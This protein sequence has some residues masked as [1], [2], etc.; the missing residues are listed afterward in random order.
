MKAWKTGQL[1][2][3]VL[4]AWALGAGWAAA[5]FNADRLLLTW[6]SDPTSTMT[7]QWLSEGIRLP[8]V[9]HEAPDPVP[10]DVP[11]VS[12]LAADAPLEAWWDDG[13]PLSYLTDPEH[14]V[15]DPEIFG[16]E[17]RLAWN[18]AGLLLGLRVRNRIHYEQPDMDL[19]WQADSIEVYFSDAVGSSHRTVLMVSPGFDSEIGE[20]RSRIF[21]RDGETAGENL[22][23]HV[24]TRKTAS[25]YTAFILLP[26]E[27]LPR[28]EPREGGGFALQ[29]YIND[30]EGP[31]REE[32][33]TIGLHPS[34]LGAADRT[35]AYAFRLAQ[36]AGDPVQARAEV[37]EDEGRFIARIY[38]A[39]ALAGE[40]VVVRSG[41][42]E[43]TS[44]E[45]RPDGFRA[46][47]EAELPAPPDGRRWGQLDAVLE[48]AWLAVM[49]APEW[50]GVESPEAATV[51]YW[52]AHAPEDRAAAVT[53]MLPV[54]QRRG[55]FRQR[56]ELTGLEPGTAYRFQ[57]EGY[58]RDY[59]FRTM[60]GNLTRPLRIALGGDTRHRQEW[61]ERTNRAAMQYRPDL[62][63][64]GGDFA[65]ADGNPENFYRWEEWF[66]ANG[67]TLID[68]DGYVVPIVAAIGNHEVQGGYYY[69]DD[70][71]EPTEVWRRDVAPF[72]YSFFAF[73]GN[74][75]YGVLDFG[76]YL[77]LILLDTD[78]TNPVEG[79][80][81]AWLETALAERAEV[82]HV[83]PVY[84]VPGFPSHRDYEGATSSRVREHWVPRFEQ[85][86]LRLV[87][88]NHDHT[89][90][91]TAPIRNGRVHPGGVVYMG[92]GAWGV[93][94]RTVHD[95]DETWYL[96]RAES[97]RH[98][99]ILT[100][101]GAH[102]HLLVV[103]ENG[104][105]I[106]EYPET[107]R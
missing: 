21:V 84:H 52:A 97:K 35:A 98:A 62:I 47:A 5:Q 68:D 79:E 86:G 46:M 70:D 11:H 45:F 87:F 7:V 33:R 15:A 74:P 64:W 81:T 56:V 57:V 26:W 30:A 14:S 101:H 18:E 29:F 93:G 63:V 88:E 75:G 20:P 25:G 10:Y 91:R 38:G 50:Y 13:L 72:F 43:V 67:A 16:A 100:L 24:R 27:N 78:H 36:E 103:D 60:P 17:G 8:V 55:I 96:E 82:P 31:D 23:V 59:G 94:V 58:D 90:K 92:D 83:I 69:N 77:S 4:I 12:D 106:D 40:R 99:I 95:P 66:E 71:Y 22:S 65:Y 80:Q 102:Q 32:W 41:N 9:E 89:Y 39:A 42:R 73:P 85:H 28:I 3:I 34:R 51:H 48:D 49:E 104:A 105:V 2:G 19:A 54:E 107:A 61:M 1:T 37:V 6:Q 53:E 76:D 44:A